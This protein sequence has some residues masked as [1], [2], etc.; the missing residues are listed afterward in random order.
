MANAKKCDICGKF[1]VVPEADPGFVWDENLNTSMVRI[2]KLN[3]EERG[4]RH[5]A[6]QFDACEDCRQ[7]V[8]DYI[9]SKKAVAN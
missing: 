4:I 7:D 1:Y 3:T 9:L 6:I 5:D 8:L 2:L